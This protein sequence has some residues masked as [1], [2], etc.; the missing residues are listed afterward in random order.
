M[1]APDQ[2]L[3][4]LLAAIVVTVSPGPDNLMVL[5]MGMSIPHQ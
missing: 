1:L 5:A 3:A 2:F 4:F